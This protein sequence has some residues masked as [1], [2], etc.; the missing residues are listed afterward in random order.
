MNSKLTTVNPDSNDPI[1][2]ELHA[3]RANL[4]QKYEGNMHTYSVAARANA[5]ALGFKFIA[6]K[7]PKA[8]TKET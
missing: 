5:I 3:V 7:N 2:E 8:E 6:S 1:V 4:L